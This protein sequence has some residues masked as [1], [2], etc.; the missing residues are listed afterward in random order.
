MTAIAA[1]AL[2]GGEQ[3]LAAL[4]ADEMSTAVRRWRRSG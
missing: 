2:G 1:A 3:R 4:R